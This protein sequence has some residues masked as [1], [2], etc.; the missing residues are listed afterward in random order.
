MWSV[1][2][3]EPLPVFCPPEVLDY[4]SNAFSNMRLKFLV[5]FR[6]S[7]NPLIICLRYIVFLAEVSLANPGT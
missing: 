2:L 5:A 1:V 4:L 6:F 7:L 3:S